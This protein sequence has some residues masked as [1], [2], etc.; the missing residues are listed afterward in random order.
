MSAHTEKVSDLEAAARK[1]LFKRTALAFSVAVLA[2]SILSSSITAAVVIAAGQSPV[3]DTILEKSSYAPRDRVNQ[4][5]AFF[6]MTPN[7]L[8]N[9]ESLTFIAPL[10]YECQSRAPHGPHPCPDGVPSKCRFYHFTDVSDICVYAYCKSAKSTDFN[11]PDFSNPDYDTFQV[12]F[13]PGSS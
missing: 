13:P 5:A 12:C 11:H 7:D 2:S 3:L 1:R 8:S 6:D 4:Y 9:M 10:D